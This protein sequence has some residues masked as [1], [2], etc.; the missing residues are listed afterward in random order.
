MYDCSENVL[1][2][3]DDEVTLPDADRKTMQTRRDTNRQRLRDG[4]ERDGKPAVEECRSQGSYAMRTMLRHHS[5]DYD[6]DDGAYFLKEDLVGPQG[7]KMTPRQAKEMVRDAVDHGF[8]KRPP[9]VRKNCVRIFYSAGYHV[10]MPVYRR[11]TTTDAG[12][13][14][15]YYE[16]AGG[17]EWKRSDARDVTKWFEEERTKSGDASQ[18]RHTVRLVKKF[19]RSRDS[20]GSHILSGFGITKLVAEKYRRH[21]DRHDKALYYTMEA[22]RDRLTLSERVEHP[23]TPNETITSHPDGSYWN[24]PKA[25]FLRDKLTDALAKMDRLFAADCTKKEA[26]QCWDKVFG[27]TYFVDGYKEEQDDEARSSANLAAPAVLSSGLLIQQGSTALG[28]VKKE[29][30]GRHA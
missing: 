17:S 12:E 15:Y 26:L 1:G 14:S 20:W 19:A 6:I 3:H 27:T 23:V 9:E 29:G 10:D 22:I 13:E 8:F 30:G 16:L 7:G 25:A 5:N 24:D 28:A 11:V 18:F 2:Y 4:L 21:S